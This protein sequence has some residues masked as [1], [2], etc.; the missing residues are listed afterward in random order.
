MRRFV[1]TAMLAGSAAV[2]APMATPQVPNNAMALNASAPAQLNPVSVQ[3]GSAIAVPIAAVSTG[4]L[5]NVERAD[6]ASWLHR[7]DAP[8]PGTA[9]VFALGFLGV[10][11]VR[12]I[13]AAQQL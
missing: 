8:E 4:L 9:W 1:A 6:S 11:A 2:F 13:R 12:R 5:Q 3:S 7:I 10:V